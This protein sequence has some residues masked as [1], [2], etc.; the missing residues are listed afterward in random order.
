MSILSFRSALVHSFSAL[1]ALAVFASNANSATQLQISNG[2]LT[3]A[4]GVLVN[5]IAYDV[6]FQDATCISVFNGCRTVDN[7]VFNNASDALSAS[8][9]LI[10]TVFVDTP[11]S[12]FN[13]NPA[14]TR[15]CV[16]FDV[17]YVFT[18]YGLFYAD[19]VKSDAVSVGV[20]YNYQANSLPDSTSLSGYRTS[21]NFAYS[22]Y[23]VYAVWSPSAVP[24][25]ETYALMLAGLGLVGA[26]ARRRKAKQA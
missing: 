25:P 7:F 9:A 22:P 2:V 17:C 8:Q 4:T 24:E 3:G 26:V 23:Q 15:G 20:A 19:T 18:P 12:A 5:G 14:L 1:I 21:D 13:S 11:G 16:F 10:D 6:S